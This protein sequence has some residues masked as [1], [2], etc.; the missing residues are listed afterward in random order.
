M[1]SGVVQHLKARLQG[2]PGPSPLQ[3]Y[4]ELRR[5]WRKSG[6]APEPRTLL[7][8][9]APATVAGSLLIAAVAAADRRAA[10]R[11]GG[12]ATTRSCWSGLL[13]LA[14]FAITLAAWDTGGGF[15]LMGASRDLTFAVFVEGVLL[16]VVLLVALSAGGSTDLVSMSASAA[17]GDVWG[18]PAHWC[19]ALAFGLVTLAETGRQPVD[20]PD[21][22]LELTMVHEGPLLEYAGR[23]LAYLQWAAAARHWIMLVLATELF[24]P[25]PGPFAVRLAVLA[26]SLPVWCAVLAMI[27][28]TQ[29]KMRILRVPLFWAPAAR[30]ACWAWPSW[31]AGRRRMSDAVTWALVISAL[32]VVV[33]RRR[34]IAIALVAAAVSDARHPSDDGRRRRVDRAAGRRRRPARQGDRAPR[35]A[36]GRRHPH[37]R[38][39]A[40]RFRAPPARAP[41]AGAGGGAGDRGAR[42]ALRAR[43]TRAPSTPRSALVA[44]G[45]VIAAVRRPVRSS[46]R[47]GSW[48]PRTASISPP[49]RC[50]VACRR[51]S[52]SA[53]SSTSSWSSRSRAPSA[54]RSTRSSAP[55]TPRCWVACVT[56]ALVIAVPA[57]PVA[58]GLL[59]QLAR[60]PATADRINVVGAV[61]TAAAAL[62]LAITALVQSATPTQGSW[63]VV[64]GATGAFLAVVAV[65]GLLS[66]LVSPGLSCGRGPQLL[67][68]RRARAW[69]YLGFHLFWAALL[70]L[71]LVNNLGVAWLLIEATTGASALLVAYS[72]RRSALEAGWKY[73]VLTTFGLTIALLGILVLYVGLAP[74]GGTLATLDWQSIARHAHGLPQTALLAFLLI[75]GGLATKIGWAPVHNWLPDAHSEAPPP[76]SALLSAALLPTVMLVAWRVVLTLGL[77]VGGGG[78]DI[79]IA[80][81]L[82]SLA[83]AVPFLWRPLAWKRL[84]AYSS[85]EHMGVLALGIG[86]AT[87]LATA[88]VVLHLAGPRARQVAGVLRGDPAAAPSAR[89]AA[90]QRAHAGVAT[91]AAR[92]RRRRS[93]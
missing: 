82:A 53:W 20:N 61:V 15:G 42:A 25:H 35:A 30:C 58:C 43:P 56:E 71:P 77:A 46:R 70:A 55:A 23:E 62:T 63:Y 65:V 52:S 64:D 79:F 1:I 8:E 87:P 88:G 14:R 92:G 17:G 12:S 18:E 19:A 90:L 21:T 76:V 93:A 85:L 32:A 91:R 36:G 66:A 73:L 41:H 44:L 26:V 86:F 33:V 28:T 78:A 27:E 29:A 22:H 34:S 67:R 57:L 47:S 7:Y 38:A 3:P 24:L 80:F 37:A 89:T 40:D 49:S 72:G 6:V 54:P 9:L 84:L 31:F 11:G 39:A 48:S 68:A 13:A 75:L 45:I 60:T 74:H 16:L 2:R 50:P 59:V 10:R 69:Y 51:S 4:R 81:G 5:L 83:V